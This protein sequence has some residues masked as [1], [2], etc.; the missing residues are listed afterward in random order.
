MSP[1]QYTGC[2][3]HGYSDKFRMS[4]TSNKP[5]IS[6]AGSDMTEVTEQKI[7]NINCD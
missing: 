6:V 4:R 3:I 1:I 5:L 7:I 2:I